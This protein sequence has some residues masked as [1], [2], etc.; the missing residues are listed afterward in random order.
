M[1]TETQLSASAIQAGKYLTFVLG[2][3]GYGLSVLKVREIIRACAA[4]RAKYARA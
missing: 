3:E 2:R 1:T 4:R